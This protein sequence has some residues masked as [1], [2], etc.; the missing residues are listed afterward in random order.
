MRTRSTRAAALFTAA[1]LTIAGAVSALTTTQDLDDGIT[2]DQL[3]QLLAGP[4]VTVANVTY[5]GDPL[6]AGTFTEDTGI[7]SFA[8]GVVLSSGWV[9]DLIGPNTDDGLSR[10]TTG[11]SDADLEALAGVPTNDAA[12]LEFDF[13]PDADTIFISYVFA[14]E[15][16]NEFTN[17]SFNDV[18]AFFVNGT[19][20]AVT[21]TGDPVSINTI[22]GGNPFGTDATNPD[23]YINNDPDDPA[24][25]IDIQPDGMT[26]TLVCNAAVNAGVANTMKLAIA[27]GSD[28]ALDSWVLLSAGGIT[29]TPPEN[30][31]DGIDNDGDGLIDG[32]DPDCKVTEPDPTTIEA[33][34]YYDAN[35][36]GVND[37]GDL[38]IA[39][40]PIFIDGADDLVVATTGADGKVATE[41][42]PGDYT[43][44]EGLAS[45]WMNVSP[46]SVDV[47]AVAEENVSV[48]FGNLCLGAG[49]G[50]TKGFWQNKNGE[51]AFGGIAGALG[52]LT[53][54]PLEDADANAF[55]P[56]SY[57]QYRNWLRSA[58]AKTPSYMLSA[59]LS[60]MALNVASGMV[61]GDALVYA[62]AAPSAN[63]FGYISVNGLMNDASISLV[64]GADDLALSDALD[65]ANNNSTFDQVGP[66]AC[67]TPTF[68]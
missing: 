6:S 62:P 64:S 5:T 54:L 47:T 16:Y 29:T 49:G 50:K 30:C 15:E 7:F 51:A 37:A 10:T 53:A 13:T 67:P 48:A 40:W 19:N 8:S 32:E 33:T 23:L 36:N 45:G 21:S 66:S 46:A 18:F 39:D 1:C 35:A 68:G 14:S 20:C 34:K 65:Q 59:Q 12:V 9:D 22:N 52:L 3:A 60:A 57:A 61:D 17:S 25:T 42:E 11:G 41:V 56:A 43:V 26:V 63:P 4:G 58:H 28:S 44:S 24:A 27:D 38:P 2:A 31:T 55:D